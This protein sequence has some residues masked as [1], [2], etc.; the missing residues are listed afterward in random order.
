MENSGD[1]YPKDFLLAEAEVAGYS[2]G[3]GAHPFRVAVRVRVLGVDRGGQRLDG[4][5]EELLVLPQRLFEAT[6][7][8]LD[9]ARHVVEVAA[10]ACDL[11]LAAH[12]RSDR[13]IALGDFGRGRGQV[14][15]RND[16]APAQD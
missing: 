2:H 5:E 6:D 3:E 8:G 13:E 7:Q 14:L 15:Q 4:L 16:E 11:I 10:E 9:V 12:R 1:V